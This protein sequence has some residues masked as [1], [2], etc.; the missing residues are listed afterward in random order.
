K[1][2]QLVYLGK[3]DPLVALYI[4]AGG[5]DMA[6]SPGQFG[7]VNTMSW[8]ANELRFVIAGDMPH[9]AL[10]ALAAVAQSQLLKK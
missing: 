2:M 10:R 6:M 8:S 4:S 1:V 5:L 7:D 3:N 9:Q